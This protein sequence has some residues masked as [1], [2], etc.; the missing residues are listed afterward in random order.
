M[1]LEL[2]AADSGSHTAR[3]QADKFGAPARSKHPNALPLG[4]EHADY[5]AQT[6]MLESLNPDN[7]VKVRKEHRV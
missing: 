1:N 5:G 4:T 7:N 3:N 6:Y 2:Q